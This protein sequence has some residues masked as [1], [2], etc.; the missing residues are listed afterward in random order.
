MNSP[1]QQATTYANECVRNPT[2]EE[3]PDVSSGDIW[4]Y[5]YEAW[6]QGYN[7]AK[8]EEKQN[9]YLTRY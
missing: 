3:F 1:E 2:P 6:M 4:E 8:F 7:Q 9:K 5:I